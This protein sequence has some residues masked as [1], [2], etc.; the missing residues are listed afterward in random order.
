MKEDI[1]RAVIELLKDLIRWIGDESQGTQT[2]RRS[3]FSTR[4]A[5]T[6]YEFNG[7]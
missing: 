6:T 7:R 3:A 2:K 5:T 4:F 1:K